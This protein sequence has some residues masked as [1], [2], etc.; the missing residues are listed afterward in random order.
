MKLLLDQSLPRTAAVLLCE[1][2]FDAVHVGNIGHASSIDATIL[3]LAQI[4]NRTL[5]TMDADF[6]TLLTL[7]G[8][9][10]PSII[11]I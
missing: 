10:L 4:E 7:S 2:G 6:H 5:I 3:E 9:V 1:A 11:R 8:A